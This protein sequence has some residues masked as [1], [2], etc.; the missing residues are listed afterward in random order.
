MNKQFTVTFELD[1]KT[2]TVTNL[3]VFV[4]GVEKKKT[5]TR[6]TKA[7]DVELEDTAIITLEENKLVFNN[8]AISDMKLE[9]KDRV[10]I[11]YDKLEDGVGKKLIP[12]IGTDF[13][14]DQEGSGNQV[15]KTNTVSYRG[16][17][18]TILTEYGNE[19]TIEAHGDGI[20]KLVSTSG[21]NEN[22]TYKETV[23]KAEEI[24]ITLLTDEG[25]GEDTAIDEMTF[26]LTM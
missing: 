1:A 19:F 7:K 3:T 5:T 18:N 20:W 8:R 9:W 22:L 6:T 15:T 21:G 10:V 2:E 24:D 13:S 26:K 4:D 23:E 16:K 12:L 11:K 14:F 25:Y 17:S